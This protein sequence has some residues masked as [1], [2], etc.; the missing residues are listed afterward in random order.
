MSGLRFTMKILQLCKKFPYPLKDG[1]SVAVTYLSKALYELGCELDLLAMNTTK[2][3][4]N[5]DD[6]PS[7]YDHYNEIILS[8]L[9]NRIK[10]KDALFN[11]FTKDSYHVVRYIS[12]DYTQKL[13]Q[14]LRNKKYDIIQLETLYLASYVPVI[15]AHSDAR[16]AMR[17][18]NVESEIWQRIAQNTPRGLKKWYVNL[19]ANRL[20]KFE[21][22]QLN[23]YDMMVAIT[24][25]DLQHFRKMGCTINGQAAPI[26]LDLSEYGSG[27][28]R[29]AS[30]EINLA[31]SKGGDVNVKP[32][33]EDAEE[34]FSNGEDAN[35]RSAEKKNPNRSSFSRSEKPPS[36]EGA[37]GWNT[38]PTNHQSPITSYQS[39]SFI[40][41]LDWMPNL[42]GL[43]WFLENVWQQ[44]IKKHPNI[45]LH[46]AGRNT[47]DWLHKKAIQNV[48]I[49]G[50]VE[51]AREFITAHPIMIVP[52]FSGS[53]M[54]VKILESMAL[55]RVTITTTL[56]LEGID[57]QP[58]TE[59][60]IADTA[61]DFIRQITFCQE[62][63][64]EL[65]QIGAAAR[66][67][68]EEHFDNKKIAARLLE[69]YKT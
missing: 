13:I 49:H 28:W 35:V 12:K 40:G 63:K 62:N 61:D 67:F 18:H 44:V 30:S 39:L 24:S 46:I 32:S 10:A 25:R 5:P 47:P 14:L 38:Q 11:L 50:E 36:L 6:I 15:R 16:I 64:N 33:E 54:R 42:E 22:D 23:T 1:E 3:Y 58:D 21:L 8:D 26:G 29:V 34:K 66:A 9:D 59:V 48:I 68:I 37:R 43:T 2:H 20:Q 4:I 65:P 17:S 69:F 41:S 57:A 31:P 52:L 45:T 55:F 27:E 7:D 19:L 56:G 60:L 53:G 51:D